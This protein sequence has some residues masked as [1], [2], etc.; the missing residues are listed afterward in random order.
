VSTTPEEVLSY[1]FPEGFDEADLQT[2]RR[3]ARKGKL[4]QRVG[5]AAR[6]LRNESHRP[7]KR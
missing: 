3:R 7:F 4:S 6:L 1:W 5:W 2:R